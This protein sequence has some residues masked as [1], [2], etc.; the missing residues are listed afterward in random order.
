M[1]SNPTRILIPVDVEELRVDLLSIA[2][3][4]VYALKGV[5]ALY[6]RRG[7]PIKP[8]LL[9]AGHERGLRPGTGNVPYIVGLGKACEIAY[10]RLREDADRLSTLREHLFDLLH[11]KI[12]QLPR[13]RLRPAPPVTRIWRAHPRFYRLWE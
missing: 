13:L 7:T 1:V 2:G 4:K 9:G 10:K 8:V 5:G 3:H 11:A 6:V 12:P